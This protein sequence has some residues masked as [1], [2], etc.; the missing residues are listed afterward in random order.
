[1]TLLR[2]DPL[3]QLAFSIYENKGVFAVLIG[4]GL[5]RSANIPTGWEITLDLIRRVALAQGQPD[6]DDWAKWYIENAGKEPNY[7]ELLEDIASSQDERRSILHSYIE[8]TT[9]EREEGTKIP[10]AAHHAIAKMVRAGYIKVI[11]T[12]NFDRLMENALRENGIEPTVVFSEDSLH[13][14]E[15]LTHSQC[16]LLKLHGD[17]KDTR[18][19]NTD[20]ELNA[21]PDKYNNLLDRIF[22]DHG[23]IVSG[24]SGEWD[25]ALRNALLRTPN[26]RY[27]TFWTTRGKLGD[28]ANTLISHRDAKVISTASA[29]EFFPLLYERIETLEK[30]HRQNPLSVDLL[31]NN[32]KRYLSKPEYRIQLDELF[33]EEVSE[34][35]KRLESANLSPNGQF[36]AEEFQ[37]RVQQYESLSEVLV[38]MVGV[39][40]RWGDGTE[41]TIVIDILRAIYRDAEK[42]GGGLV[43]W[44]SLRSY[45]AVLIFTAY[46]LGLTKSQRWSTLH[47]LFTST[48][49]RENRDSV[50]IVASLF[51]GS[52]KGGDNEIWQKLQGYDRRKT[53][54]DDHLLEIMINW[55]DSFIGI[56]SNFELLYERFETL[57][58]LAHFE[59]NEV[60]SLET[61]INDNSRQVLAWMPMGRVGWNSSGFE[62]ILQELE[63]E[64][65]SIVLLEARFALGLRRLYELFLENFKRYSNRMHW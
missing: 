24:W 27:P 43:V 44:L 12:T 18:I 7:S 63:N 45:P 3:T 21:Y 48:L 8:P 10:T 29:D 31:V 6:Q 5:S 39:L 61:A 46:G 14:A 64:S 51:L 62:S 37:S 35:L 28:G 55:K 17:Y 36:S 54:L 47:Q 32:T 59:G 15:P 11:I 42:I 22:D 13:G 23:L 57:A 38:K 41:L 50:R 20:N 33:A 19:L 52:W 60:A 2:N 30:S 58:S 9:Q 53:A 25:H 1:M 56:E 65:T 34:L 4:S 26:R 40:G 49:A 16:Y